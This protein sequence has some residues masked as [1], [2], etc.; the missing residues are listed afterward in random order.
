MRAASGSGRD[1]RARCERWVLLGMEGVSFS[2]DGPDEAWFADITYVRTHQGWLYL[3]VVMDIWSRRIVGWSMS[4]RMTAEL[5]DDALKMAIARRRPPEG[6][7]HHSDHGSQYVSLQLGRTMR[8][9]GI[10]PSMG[11]ISSPWDNAAMESLMG[12][13]KAECVHARTFETRE[14][15]ALEIFDYIECFYNRK[16]IHSALGYLSPEEFERANRPGEG[17]RPMAA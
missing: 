16:R 6:R 4:A 15:A 1:S 13:I 12:L 5:A 9:A 10:V 11:S 7:V 3:A 8:G 2:A 14:Q 17:R